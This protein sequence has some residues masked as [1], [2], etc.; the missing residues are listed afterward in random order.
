M[1]EQE[2]KT[3]AVEEKKDVKQ[4]ASQVEEKKENKSDLTLDEMKVELAKARREAAK[5]RTEKND[6]E[7]EKLTDTERLAKEIADMKAELFAAKRQTVAMKYKL[8][9]A[10]ADR[11][12]GETQEEL[13]EDAKALA[14]LIVKP[15]SSEAEKKPVTGIDPT[16]PSGTL[17]LTREAIEKMSPAEIN[18]N[19]EAVSAALKEK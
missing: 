10:L 2:E 17:K 9:E 4:E 5:Y 15:E 14:A 6:A 7:K 3:P 19:W 11:L 8:P 16:A 13:E 18:K 12:K 1:S